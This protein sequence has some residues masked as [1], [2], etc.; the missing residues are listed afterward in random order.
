[1]LWFKHLENLLPRKNRQSK[2]RDCE[3]R[4]AEIGVCGSDRR[5]LQ[6]PTT[7]KL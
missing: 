7:E 1:M 4:V 3:L 5:I 6:A 2:F